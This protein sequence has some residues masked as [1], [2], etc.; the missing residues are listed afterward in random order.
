MRIIASNNKKTLHISHNDWLRIG[1]QAGW[2]KT[3][4]KS[5][6]KTMLLREEK[7]KALKFAEKIRKE[8]RNRGH[9]PSKIKEIRGG[10]VAIQLVD[11]HRVGIEVKPWASQNNKELEWKSGIMIIVGS[12][13][14]K[15]FRRKRVSKNVEKICNYVEKILSLYEKKENRR[16]RRQEIAD[17]KRD[18]KVEQAKLERELE[19]TT[20]TVSTSN[21]IWNTYLLN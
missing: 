16:L 6:K 5:R 2:I 13:V 15:Y 10:K 3:S 4:R 20:K 17:Q 18:E 8:L 14:D 11:G 7:E 12:G 1:Q 19:K 21:R 9:E